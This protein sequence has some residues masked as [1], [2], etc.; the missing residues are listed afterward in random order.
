MI[1]FTS[2][3]TLESK[4][5]PGVKVHMNKFSVAHRAQISL[6]LAD[7][8]AKINE[9]YRKM[10]DYIPVPD[11]TDE[12][13]VVIKPGDSKEVREAKTVQRI[14]LQS[15]IKALEDA[16]IKPAWL[17]HYVT[18]VE[19]AELDGQPITAELL[20]TGADLTKL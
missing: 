5:F 19:G 20:V 13:G 8:R 12:H 10:L 17:R 6:A 3:L 4:E 9:V 7:C 11:E 1:S 14:I 15:E 2:K 18:S 16:Y